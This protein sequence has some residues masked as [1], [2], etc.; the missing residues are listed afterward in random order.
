MGEICSSRDEPNGEDIQIN[1]NCY[2]AP[3]C[4]KN[5]LLLRWD[6]PF[7]WHETKYS[8]DIESWK[9]RFQ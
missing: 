3:T 9:D 8:E 7:S 2:T 4:F 6:C 1:D 5:S